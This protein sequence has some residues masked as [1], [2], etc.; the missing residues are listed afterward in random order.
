METT[1]AALSVMS[2]W[3]LYFTGKSSGL[4]HYKHVILVVRENTPAAPRVVRL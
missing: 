4:I 2:L 1:A 3:S